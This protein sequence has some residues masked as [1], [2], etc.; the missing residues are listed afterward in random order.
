MPER[1][2]QQ[3]DVFSQRPGDGNRWPWCWTPR[4]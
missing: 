2:F 1:A 3:I 4:A